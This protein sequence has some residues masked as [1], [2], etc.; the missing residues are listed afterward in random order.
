MKARYAI[1]GGSA[2]KARL[3][4][5]SSVLQ[6]GTTS[7]LLRAGV[8]PGDRCIDVGCGGGNISRH[9]ARLVGPR[10]TVLGVDLDAEVLGLALQDAEKEGL[11]NVG[12]LV[13]DAASIPGGPY[14][15]AYARFLLSHV[16]DPSAVLSAMVGSLA[17]GAVV[18]VEDTDF[19]GT[20]CYPESRAFRRFGQ[21]VRET[22]RRRGGNADIGPALPSLLRAAGIGEVV[23][24]VSQPTA[25]SGDV[26]SLML[27]TLQRMWESILEEDVASRPELEQIAA[28]LH[29]F[30]DEPTTLLSVPR[31]IQAWGR[32][33]AVHD[34][35]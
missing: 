15:L 24:N 11:K 31:V 30:C 5:L 17:P 4:V 19:S 26:K 16:D 32:K 3:D 13:A 20:L 28:D 6:H 25:M 9:L 1:E 7:L 8:M 34:Q 33:R 21:L 2:G 29:D 10:G 12:F 27:L 35:W 18:I 14:D 22:V 23:V